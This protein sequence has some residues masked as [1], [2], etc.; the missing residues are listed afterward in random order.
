MSSKAMQIDREIWLLFPFSIGAAAALGLVDTQILHFIDLA[1]VP[2]EIASLELSWARLLA[3]VSL[4]A[5][6]VNREKPFGEQIRGLEAAEV[7]MVYATIGLIVA[8]PLFPAFA[9]FLNE[10][11]AGWI[12]FL[13]QGAGFVI[14][15]YMN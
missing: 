12:A 10:T 1:D 4:L 3:I 9:E 11:T 8:P 13:I 6:V 14:I 7:W 15:S 5:I 2:L